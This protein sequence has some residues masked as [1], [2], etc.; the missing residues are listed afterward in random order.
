MWAR[1][2][3]VAQHDPVAAVAGRTLRLRDQLPEVVLVEPHVVV[4]AGARI[5]DRELPARGG[6]ARARA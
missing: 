4:D 3:L 1:R 5:A 2:G 6:V